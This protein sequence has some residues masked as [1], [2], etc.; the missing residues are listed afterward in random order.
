MRENM[1]SKKATSP[2]GIA[3]FMLISVSLIIAYRVAMKS[4]TGTATIGNNS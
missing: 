4:M 2:L 1:K 3:I